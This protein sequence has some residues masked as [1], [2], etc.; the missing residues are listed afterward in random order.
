MICGVKGEGREPKST[1]KHKPR[2]L[3]VACGLGYTITECNLNAQRLTHPISGLKGLS[4]T[5]QPFLGLWSR[6]LMPLLAA[7]WEE[8]VGGRKF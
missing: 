8:A 4:G 7:F 6:Q 1:L 3:A 2:G 5:C